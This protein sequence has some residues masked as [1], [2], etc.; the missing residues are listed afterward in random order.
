MTHFCCGPICSIPSLS[1]AAD[2]LRHQG[3]RSM[4]MSHCWKNLFQG[5]TKPHRRAG[6]PAMVTPSGAHVEPFESRCYLSISSVFN[7]T[8]GALNIASNGKD[9]IVIGAGNDGN[10]TLNGATLSATTNGI[11]GPVA[12][13]AVTTLSVTG[14]SGNN[15][16]NLSGVS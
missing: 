14:G 13:N 3:V 16:I 7:A 2:H 12:A 9:A 6:T 8:T 15:V 1:C 11:A 10:V 4:L 5:R